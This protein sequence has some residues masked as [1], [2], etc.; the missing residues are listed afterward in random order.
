MG[1]FLFRKSPPP[2]ARAVSSQVVLAVLPFANQTGLD[3]DNYL[4]EGLTDN[5]IRQFSELPRIRVIARAA[6]DGIDRKRV[7]SD[8]GATALLS[9]ALQRGADGRLTLDA[10]LSNASD[11]IVL[12]SSQYLPDE[13][14]LRPVQA[15]IVRDVIAGLG[16][17]LDAP[18]SVAA[19]RPLTSSPAAFQE[20]LR[21]ETAIENGDE[22]SMK[23]AAYLLEDAVKKDPKFATA[24][25]SLAE[26]QVI[27][28]IYF[29]APGEY[30]R[31]ARTAAQA[32]IALDPR[33][34][35]AHAVLGLVKLLFDW[36]FVGSEKELVNAGSE[37]AALWTFGCIAHLHDRNGDSRHAEEVL[38]SM[39]EFNPNSPWLITEMGCLNYYGGHY[40]ESVRY[41]RQSLAA[42]PHGVVAAWG[43]G[44]SLG[45]QGHYREAIEELKNFNTA[46]GIEHPLLDAEIGYLQAASGDRA[47]ALATIER[48]QFIA[49]HRGF[50]DPF[51]T[52]EI[53]FALNDQK[54]AYAWLDKAY[55]IHST[56]LV[57]MA[58][59]PRWS[60]AQGDPRF[61][62]LWDRMT[63]YGSQQAGARSNGF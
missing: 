2:P 53:Y 9:G 44:R 59:D 50:V 25:A 58:T 12:R 56:F 26:T 55:G 62:T 35:N 27:I 49:H 32:A 24:F 29:E 13:T 52:A 39:L 20:F 36:D 40:E 19:L 42:A 10:E 63:R 47:G 31:Q 33:N 28:G 18:E 45:R 37:Q 51:F 11:G 17:H 22:G 34:V 16:M 5:L 6:M 1:L 14:D 23:T 3:A 4:T 60:P 7:A 43:L 41:Y 46:F 8:L 38:R 15:D 57:S 21:A 30:F 61:Q 54:Q 48:L